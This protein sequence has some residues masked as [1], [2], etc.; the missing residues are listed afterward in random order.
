M[1]FF[2]ECNC[3]SLL[4]LARYSALDLGHQ[5][6]LLVEEVLLVLELD[7]GAAELGEKDGVADLKRKCNRRWEQLRHKNIKIPSN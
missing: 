1:T 3:S 6:R 4:S 2:S 7:L 5:L